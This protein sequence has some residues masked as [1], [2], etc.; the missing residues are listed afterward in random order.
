MAKKK[1]RNVSLSN[2]TKKYPGGG[3]ITPENGTGVPND[4]QYSEENVIVYPPNTPN[5]G[6]TQTGGIKPVTLPDNPF[7]NLD[8]GAMGGI[9]SQL[10]EGSMGQ[11]NQ[12]QRD[13]F[14]PIQGFHGSNYLQKGGSVNDLSKK[15]WR[16]Y[17]KH[18]KAENFYMSTPYDPDWH[19]GQTIAAE[20]GIQRLPEYRQ[21]VFEGEDV[22]D[23]VRDAIDPIEGFGETHEDYA[24]AYNNMAKN[25]GYSGL[26][27]F[28]KKNKIGRKHLKNELFKQYG[29]KLAFEK[30]AENFPSPGGKTVNTPEDIGN[31]QKGGKIKL[32]FEDYLKH[33]N[34]DFA[35]TTYYNLREAYDE[36][37]LELMEAWRK[38]PDKNH[39]PDT[40]KKPGHPS[41]SIESKYYKPG[42]KSGYWIGEKYI[43]LEE[44]QLPPKDYQS[45]GKVKPIYVTDPDD[46]RYRAYQDSLTAYN[47]GLSTQQ[48]GRAMYDDIRAPINEEYRRTH[49]IVTDRNYKASSYKNID[50]IESY[51]EYYTRKPLTLKEKVFGDS[52]QNYVN[53]DKVNKLLG[54]NPE[55]VWAENGA[56]WAKFKKPVQ[57]V[58]INMED[59][60]SNTNDEYAYRK[61]ISK[62]PKVD[63]RFDD[64]NYTLQRYNDGDP[65]SEGELRFV[66]KPPRPNR[67]TDP[68][69]QLS[70]KQL[71][72]NVPRPDLTNIKN[73]LWEDGRLIQDWKGVPNLK[74]VS[75]RSKKNGRLEPIAIQN[76]KGDMIEY[77]K[78]KDKPLPKGFQH[79]EEFQQ[80]GNVNTTG[81]TPGTPTYNNP[82]NIIPSNNITMENTPFNV[83][84]QSLETGETKLMKPGK[85]YKFKNTK[86]VLEIPQGLMSIGKEPYYQKG[87]IVEGEYEVNSVSKKEIERLNKVGYKV[88]IIG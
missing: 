7:A 46:P 54:S 23:A 67:I 86:N 34:P 60:P 65:G 5:S 88:D 3:P 69:E 48:L 22:Y 16:R 13:Y 64:P 38:D 53:G 26:D 57:P 20:A 75:A 72:T 58:K 82:F 61:Q 18:D 1:K 27:D 63:P 30:L 25:L 21:N 24:T 14:N 51:A 71:E 47:I 35:D 2:Y 59:T 8:W 9:F 73:G 19:K 15:D 36:L 12:R 80:G 32:P 49:D 81:Y 10:M 37:P 39:L 87:G 77:K 79:P 66:R 45:G 42:M 52:A 41:F 40:Y 68:L 85:N 83:M 4:P 50:P 76:A 74:I 55:T 33:V 78:Y 62:M 6:T 31:Y 29:S 11:T 44:G 70:I 56:S 28:S 43:P 17:W 84:G